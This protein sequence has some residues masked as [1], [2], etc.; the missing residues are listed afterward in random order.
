MKEL[1]DHVT[2]VPYTRT[3]IEHD[4]GSGNNTCTSTAM[5]AVL[6][7]VGKVKSEN[8][9]PATGNVHPVLGYIL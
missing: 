8:V 5:V 1:R 4:S 9:V 6:L 2:M 3:R 7:V